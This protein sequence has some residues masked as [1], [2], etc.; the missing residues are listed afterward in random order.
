MEEAYSQVNLPFDWLESWVQAPLFHFHAIYGLH[1]GFSLDSR[2]SSLFISNQWSLGTRWHKQLHR[3]SFNVG[4]DLAFTW[5]YFYRLGFATAVTSWINIPNT[6]IGFRFKDIVFTLKGEYNVV[7]GLSSKQGD[8][9]MVVEKA[10]AN[11]G[12]LGLY[13]EQRVHNDKVLVLGFKNSYI[14]HHFMSWPAFSTFDRFY[15]IPEFYV[16]LIL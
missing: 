11:G 15:N 10:F 8:H 16:G 2:F 12:C 1:N 6:S 4:Y 3:F 13:M 5:G 9:Q 14:K 7:M